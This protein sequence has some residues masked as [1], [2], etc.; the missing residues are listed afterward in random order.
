VVA[1]V[2]PFFELLDVVGVE[3]GITREQVIQARH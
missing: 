3:Q 2:D 1:L